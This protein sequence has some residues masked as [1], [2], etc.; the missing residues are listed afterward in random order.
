MIAYHQLLGEFA[1]ADVVVRAESLD[2][3]RIQNPKV[4]CFDD[5]KVV[6]AMHHAD[7]AGHHDLPTINPRKSRAVSR[8]YPRAERFAASA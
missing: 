4:L 2:D 1:D 7:R 6:G 3:E 8:R 5:A